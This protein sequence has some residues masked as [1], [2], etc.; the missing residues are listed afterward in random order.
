MKK[1]L[2]FI[3]LIVGGVWFYGS[4]LPREHTARS[5][6]VLVSPVDTVFKAVR[7]IG[8]Q[9]TWWSDAKSV[10]ALRGRRRE[11]WELNMGADGI[12]TVEVKSAQQGRVVTQIVPSEN[13]TEE[14]MGWGGTW[15]YEV[16]QSAAGTEVEVTEEGWV[17]SPFFRVLA[18]LRGRYRTVDSY[19]TSLAAHFGEVATP[20]HATR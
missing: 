12:I 2:L 8:Q 5:T 1:F 11:T 14:S 18:K 7:N 4:R 20:R 3:G 15:T 16:F 6:I 9:P 10:R 13:E 19:L 17:E